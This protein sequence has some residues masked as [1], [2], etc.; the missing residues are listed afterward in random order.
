MPQ[1]KSSSSD[2]VACMSKEDMD[3]LVKRAVQAAV[4]MLSQDLNNYFDKQL[5][6]INDK[7]NVLN[8]EN[9]LLKTQ[10]SSLQSEVNILTQKVADQSS[11]IDN[12]EQKIN[13][14]LIWA[15]KNEQYS[16]RN[17]LKIHGLRVKQNES[18]CDATSRL[19]KDSLGIDLNEGDITIAHPVPR[20]IR[21]QDAGAGN[22]KKPS[23]P[24]PVIVVFSAAARDQ[25]EEAIKQRKK[26][27]GQG[28][29]IYEDLTSMNIKLLNRLKN[30]EDISSV[31]SSKG[32][33]IAL[34]K[35]GDK[36]SFELFDN[37][38][39]KLLH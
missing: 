25:R 31:W 4:D 16:R 36:R 21:N 5:Q 34:S 20:R 29:A 3:M 26:L 17:N 24:D 15:N 1:K 22:S 6:A 19:F 35:S 32:K 27:K 11:I 9:T 10:V 38:E 28:M 18:Y 39:Q 7:H 23:P 37:I 13:D 14:A 33:V 30:H 2:Q 12:Y 8:S